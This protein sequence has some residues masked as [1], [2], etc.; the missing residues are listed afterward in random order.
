M[1]D[2]QHLQQKAAWVRRETIR[3][4]GL[5]PETR[6]ASSLSPV[7][8][9]VALLYG[10]ILSLTAE[11]RNREDRD[12]LIISKGHGS[13]CCYP[14]FADLGF[15][16][17]EELENICKEGSFLGGIPDTNIPGYETING[18]LG[19]GIGVGSGIALALKCK[20]SRSSVVVVAGDG[21]FHEGSMWEGIMFAAHHRLGNLSVVIDCNKLCMLG[22]CQDIVTLEPLE[23][24]LSAFGWET[25]RVD[26]HSLPGLHAEFSTIKERAQDGP[27]LALIA[28]TIKG[29]GVPCLEN[30]P[31]CH[32]RTLT[33]EEVRQAIGGIV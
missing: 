1:I 27:P 19:L 9:F 24:R 11:N 18:S 32:I 13:I 25:R 30:D 3:L 23:Q 10:N 33:Q 6:I 15:F 22:R 14:I 4:H 26:G 8:L 17:P 28:D 12:R 16:P 21:E 29:K 31:L 2:C 7:E 5:A 20:G